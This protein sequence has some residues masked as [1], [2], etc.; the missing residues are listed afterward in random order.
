MSPSQLHEA[1]DMSAMC[2]PWGHKEHHFLIMKAKLLLIRLHICHKH[3][4]QSCGVTLAGSTQQRLQMPS[5]HNTEQQKALCGGKHPQSDQKTPLSN[6]TEAHQC[7][8]S[9]T[10]MSCSDVHTHKDDH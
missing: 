7:H 3:N 2:A 10:P 4:D 6:R 5:K 1:Q 8:P 9:S